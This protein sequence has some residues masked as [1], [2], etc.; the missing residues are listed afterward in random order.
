M[1]HAAGPPQ[2]L[3]RR[4]RQ[5]FIPS[6]RHSSAAGPLVSALV[7][8]AG[9]VPNWGRGRWL[10]DWCA[11]FAVPA[12]PR[13]APSTRHGPPKDPGTE[14]ALQWVLEPPVARLWCAAHRAETRHD[15]RDRRCLFESTGLMLHRCAVGHSPACPFSSSSLYVQ[16]G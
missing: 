1:G 14:C 3:V 12:P 4:V 9:Q 6:I 15:A 10:A 8:V 2:E 5:A 7:N 11:P 13:C 16:R